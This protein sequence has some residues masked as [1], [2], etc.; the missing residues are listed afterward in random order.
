M[1]KA[2]KVLDNVVDIDLSSIRKKRFRIDGDDDRILELN[3][4]DMGILGRLQNSESKI[5]ELTKLAV[6][7]WPDE[8]DENAI[9]SAVKVFN[10][11]DKSMREIIDY[12]FDAPVS[13]VCVPSGTM[14]DP[15]NGEFRY[16]HIMNIIGKLYEANITDEVT[17]VSTRIK[18]HTAKYTN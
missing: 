17:K 1:A 9:E 8:A 11:A 2:K 6:D 3:T 10:D 14:F 5:S 4:S 13:K 16:E 15:I 18:K 12:I 7:N